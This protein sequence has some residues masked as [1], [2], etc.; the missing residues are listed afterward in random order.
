M[1]AVK[2]PKKPS[3]A[4]PAPA[5]KV[6]KAAP[7]KTKS[8]DAVN[9]STK[10]KET[11]ER[12]AAELSGLRSG[13]EESLAQFKIKIHGRLAELQGCVAGDN[14]GGDS[15]PPIGVVTAERALIL[16]S[17]LKMKPGK[18]RLKDLVHMAELVDELR[19]SLRRR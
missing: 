2:T 9:A 13:F 1:V 18:G 14:P 16:I 3:K 12:L 10:R 5:K 19:K 15:I 17:E 6:T 11:L 8:A 4:K 7:K